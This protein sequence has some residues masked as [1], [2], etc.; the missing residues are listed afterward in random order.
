[1]T[2][3]HP[4]L[5]LPMVRTLLLPP[6]D[7]GHLPRLREA[8]LPYEVGM[9]S[10]WMGEALIGLSLGKAGHLP[11]PPCTRRKS[12]EWLPEQVRVWGKPAWPTVSCMASWLCLSILICQMGTRALPS[13]GG[14]QG[15]HERIRAQHVSACGKCTVSGRVS[16]LWL[17]SSSG[18]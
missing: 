3:K 10:L 5:A 8:Q 13:R 6:S 16:S 17:S 15:L 2:S 14:W 7:P 9:M 18:P 12:S 4:H 1:M 11:A